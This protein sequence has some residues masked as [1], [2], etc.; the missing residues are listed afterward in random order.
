[1]QP[2]LARGAGR[3]DPAPVVHVGKAGILHA[4]RQP[5]TRSD[6]LHRPSAPG[7]Q[8]PAARAAA[9]AG[10]PWPAW[11][12]PRR[13]PDQAPRASTR[14]HARPDRPNEDRQACRH[15]LVDVAR[16]EGGTFDTNIS[17][18][19]RG[20]RLP[21]TPEEPVLHTVY[22]AVSNGP[23]PRRWKRWRAPIEPGPRRARPRDGASGPN[24]SNESNGVAWLRRRGAGRDRDS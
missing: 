24:S 20:C 7:A 16:V 21:P 17:P 2:G 22:C 13:S 8:P 10:G 3:A 18:A 9:H 19:A 11:S 14:A 4:P 1:M 6:R 12:R 15:L 23:R 5:S